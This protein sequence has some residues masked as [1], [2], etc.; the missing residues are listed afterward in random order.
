MITVSLEI[1]SV[2]SISNYLSLAHRLPSTERL[3]FGPL[4]READL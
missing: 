3:D 2:V 4:E 1:I